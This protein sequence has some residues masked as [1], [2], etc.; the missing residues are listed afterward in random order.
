MGRYYH[1]DGPA[2]VIF[3]HKT[4]TIEPSGREGTDKYDTKL[5]RVEKRSNHV[6]E[7]EKVSV[8]M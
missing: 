3:D 8:C 1:V 2:T 6:R 7:I 5:L 4:S